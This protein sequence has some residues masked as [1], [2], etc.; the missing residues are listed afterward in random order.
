MNR[1]LVS[2]ARCRANAGEEFRLVFAS[3]FLMP[4]VVIRHPGTAR[5]F[6]E[7][8]KRH[9]SY[10]DQN[11]AYTSL[12]DRITEVQSLDRQSENA[13]RHEWVPHTSNV[14]RSYIRDDVILVQFAKCYWVSDSKI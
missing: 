2:V 8:L 10:G 12:I 14:N 5:K 11:T 6:H 13:D 9:A 7:F 1:L 3:F 4:C